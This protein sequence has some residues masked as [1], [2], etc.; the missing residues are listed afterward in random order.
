[1][2]ELWFCLIMMQEISFLGNWNVENK[3]LNC[4]NDEIYETTIRNLKLWISSKQINGCNLVY[5]Q[6]LRVLGQ[7]ASWKS[8][9][10]N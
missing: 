3:F 7:Y 10:L 8:K 5:D 1:M 6:D 9:F 4:K 2:L